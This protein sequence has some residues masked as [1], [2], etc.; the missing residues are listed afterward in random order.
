MTR[1]V[2]VVVKAA[3]LGVVNVVKDVVNVVVDA[4]KDCVGTVLKD[5]ICV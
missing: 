2:E 1:Q 4:V 3:A 5:C